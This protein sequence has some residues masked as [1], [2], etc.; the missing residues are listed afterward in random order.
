MHGALGDVLSAVADPDGAPGQATRGGSHGADHTGRVTRGG[1]H[2]AGHTGA[3][4]GSRG[5][6]GAPG[7]HP[8]LAK[9]FF[10]S[11]ACVLFWCSA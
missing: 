5:L 7:E 8:H 1:S 4:G 2:G 10:L 3:H 9:F 11:L 6:T